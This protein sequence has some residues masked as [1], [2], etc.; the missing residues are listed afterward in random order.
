[1]EVTSRVHQTPELFE[2]ANCA[3]VALDLIVCLRYQTRSAKIKFEGG[4]P[5]RASDPADVNYDCYISELSFGCDTFFK[6]KQRTWK[7]A[8]RSSEVGFVLRLKS[9]PHKWKRPGWM[10]ERASG[11]AVIVPH[12]NDM[13]MCTISCVFNQPCDLCNHG[14]QKPVIKTKWTHTVSLT[15]TWSLLLGQPSSAPR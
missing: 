8:L 2:A 3:R 5:K 10:A 14:T 12:D 6:G 4:R 9:S 11:L 7:S 15:K 13:S 1:M